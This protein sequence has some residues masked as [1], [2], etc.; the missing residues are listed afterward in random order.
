[1][2]RISITRICQTVLLVA[3]CGCDT[4][5]VEPAADAGTEVERRNL[6][7]SGAG[8][9]PM[10]FGAWS[11][12]INVQSIP[13]THADF[14]T[15][16]LDGCP[17]TSRDGKRFFMASTRPGSDS[18]DIWMARRDD[19]DDPWGEPV[20][21]GE[22]VNSAYNDYCPTLAPDGRTFF[23]VS[24]R[25]DGCGGA[26][27][28]ATRMRSDDTFEPV[29]HLGC[30][31]NSAAD[32]QSPFPIAEPG[33]G[34]VLYFSSFRAGGYA[35]DPDGAVSGDS[36][37]YVSRF[38]GSSFGTP[39]LVPGVNTETSDGHPNVRRD[40]REIFFFS[41]RT[42][43]GGEGATDIYAATRER[44]SHAWMTPV[45]LGDSVNSIAGESRPSLSWDGTTL[46][47]G[48][49]RLGGEGGSDIYVT[50]RSAQKGKP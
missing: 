17:F 48:S 42:D 4:E 25:P 3:V 15:T 20:N 19:P 32:E 23:F 29:H 45:A 18:L 43:L 13:G 8:H 46:Y 2:P 27:I 26:D 49:P 40:G 30:T 35:P 28:Y 24:T 10:A 33:T 34:P 5:V 50:T 38:K 44:T 36:D 21:V 39:Q 16:V 1:M 7:A 12:A 31:V 47:F 9:S 22:P 6:A 41:A 37:I 14:N 11:A